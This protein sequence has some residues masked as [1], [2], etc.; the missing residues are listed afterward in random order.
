MRQRCTQHFRQAWLNVELVFLLLS[1]TD[2]VL[3]LVGNNRIDSDSSAAGFS[4]RLG[5]ENTLGSDSSDMRILRT[6][7]SNPKGAKACNQSCV[8]G[9]NKSPPCPDFAIRQGSASHKQPRGFLA[10]TTGVLFL[11][12]FNMPFPFLL[13]FYLLFGV[14]LGQFALIYMKGSPASAGGFSLFCITAFTL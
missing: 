1:R 10:V 2:L 13:L 6:G 9:I 8:W 3:S 14:E 12:S 4:L 7:L 11:L 5:R